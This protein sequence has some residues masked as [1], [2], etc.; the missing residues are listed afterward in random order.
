MDKPSRV[1]EVTV[2]KIPSNI[3]LVTG[4][5][6][7]ILCGLTGARGL[8]RESGGSAAALD[9]FVENEG[10]WDNRF[11]RHLE[12][13][14]AIE[15]E[16]ASETSPVRR[17]TLKRDI[18]EHYLL[19]GQVDGAIDSLKQL[20]T[21]FGSTAAPAEVRKLRLTLALAYLRY[22]E[23]QNCTW[24]HSA[25][26]CLFPLQQ[27]GIHRQK[28]GAQQAIVL[29]DELLADPSATAEQR[30]N[31]RW[32]LNVAHMA[33]GSY[34]GSLPQ[35]WLLPEQA[36]TSPHGL[37]RFRDT[38]T[39][40]GISA[41]GLAGGAVMDDFDNDG[42]L[43]LMTSS[44]GN[45]DA[46]Q[47][48][49]NRGKGQFEDL[50]KTAIPAGINGGLQIVQGDYDNDGLLDLLLLRGAWLHEHGRLPRTLL[51]NEGGNRFKDVTTSAGLAAQYPTQSAAWADFDGD[52]LLDLVIGN[53]IARPDVAWPADT[54][55][56][57]LYRN[58]GKGGF[59]EIAAATGLNV[60]GWVKGL[61]WGDYD[62]D[63]RPDLYVSIMGGSNQ[64]FHNLGA[65]GDRLPRFE[66]VTAKAG[67]AEPRMSFAC[68]FW[69]FDNDGWLDLFVAG[70]ASDLAA[71][72]R[73]ALG[74]SD[75]RAEMPRL[76]RNNRD[77]RF[78]DVAPARGLAQPMMPMGSNYGDLDNDGWLDLYLGTGAPGLEFLVPNRMF[79]NH[80]GTRFDDVTTAGG[81]GHLQKGHGVAWGD[82][83]DDGDQDIYEDIGG[84]FD[85]DRFW[86]VLF[87]NPGTAGNHWLTLRLQGTRANHFGIGSRLRVEVVHADGSERTIHH[88]VGSGGSFGGNSL[89]AELG[90]G[91]ATAIKA[92]EIDWAG[93][94]QRQRYTGLAMD[95]VHVLIESSSTTSQP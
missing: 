25:D 84:A 18:A 59:E 14:Q 91:A 87:E 33:A 19:A 94:G 2:V 45:G 53:E 39:A 21:T 26:S 67:V 37:P 72:S 46:L 80:G 86:N 61:S 23:L 38:A 16:M 22:G 20:L 41:F 31:D 30:L 8:L 76:Y 70:Y 85:A 54:P 42:H 34:P 36:F 50:S 32:L 88:L 27:G 6:A 89:Q 15:A 12:K 7:A 83:D 81:F 43:D 77:G 3:L 92:V 64:L 47:F 28:L 35:Q 5:V 60:Q 56:V 52:G 44:W 65:S 93:S 10:V 9:K 95:R 82:I 55:N 24:N 4:V 73:A 49:R 58:T 40:R 75:P 69:D 62:N 11:N 68:W 17:L 66:D 51:R 63:G 74:E 13:A 78:T 29:L 79:H 57:E 71:A 48:F 90:L 1:P